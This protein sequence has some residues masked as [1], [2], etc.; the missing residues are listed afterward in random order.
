M[1]KAIITN[2]GSE[3][4]KSEK[5]AKAFFSKM[6]GKYTDKQTITDKEDR[7]LLVELVKRHPSASEKIGCG[8][9]GFFRDKAEEG[10]SCFYIKRIDGSHEHF[11][12]KTAFEKK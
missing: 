2:I 12:I 4:F 1:P 7:D 9:A 10:T 6:L 5:A 8:I 11:S 3:E